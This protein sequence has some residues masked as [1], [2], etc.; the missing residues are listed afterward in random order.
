MQAFS[1]YDWNGTGYVTAEDFQN[2]KI[3]FRLPFTREELRFLLENET[4][5]KRYDQITIDQFVKNFMPDSTQARGDRDKSQSSD[6]DHNHSL[7]HR[8]DSG[9]DHEKQTNP[10]NSDHFSFGGSTLTGGLKQQKVAE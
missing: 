4:V 1:A 7:D 10:D 3:N 6:D 2:A 9:A 8:R 5:F